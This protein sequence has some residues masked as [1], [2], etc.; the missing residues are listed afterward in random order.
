MVD[1][2][3]ER[4]ERDRRFAADV[5]H[6]L[7]SPLQTLAA[8]ASVLSSRRDRL[9]E[10][11]A[12]AAGLVAD[13]VA[14]FQQL[15]NDLIELAGSDRP[16]DRAPLHVADLAR[17]VCHSRGLSDDLVQAQDPDAT[18]MVD[19]RRVEQILVNLLDNATAYGGGPT[20]VR[21]SHE[22]GRYVVEVEDQGPGV[23]P[24][25]KRVIFH[26]FVRGRTANARADGNGTGLGLALV[27]EHAAAHGGTATVLDRPGGGAR[28]RVELSEPPR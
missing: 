17:R 24:E 19:V 21:L 26:R 27:A 15:L 14:R 13:E 12:A 20:A 8:A 9:D 16:V 4:N 23:R 1:Q 22:P 10:R 2:L 3:A 28:F 11:S 7:R 18:W 6:E 5:S 25:D